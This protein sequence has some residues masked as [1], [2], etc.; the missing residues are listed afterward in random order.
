MNPVRMS[1]TSDHGQLVCRWTNAEER[2]R[3][4]PSWMLL[5]LPITRECCQDRVSGRIRRSLEAIARLWL[6][7][8]AAFV[9]QSGENTRILPKL[10]SRLL[11]R[12]GDV[13]Q[14]P[15]CG[16]GAPTEENGCRLP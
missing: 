10:P 14:A 7:I 5:A 1:W 6:P 9:R 13:H 12:L 16:G 2:N 8:S 11:T 3:Y 15:T 4:E